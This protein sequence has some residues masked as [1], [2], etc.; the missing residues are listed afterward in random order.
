MHQLQP[1][2]SAAILT[3]DY[4][5]W[6]MNHLPNMTLAIG[7]LTV[8]PAAYLTPRSSDRFRDP[9]G[10]LPSESSRCL[11]PPHLVHLQANVPTGGP[12]AHHPLLLSVCLP[13]C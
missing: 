13:P 9:G 4:R 7:I 3:S 11:L 8:R 5:P 1:V 10:S 12:T 2:I 6:P